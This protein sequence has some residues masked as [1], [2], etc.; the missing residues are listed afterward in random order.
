MKYFKI[1]FMLIAFS[2]I[3][4]A[5]TNELGLLDEDFN[6]LMALSGSLFGFVF[7]YFSIKIFI[8]VGGKR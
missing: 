4:L 3:C 5:D 2:S 8:N 1:L 6:F 7:L